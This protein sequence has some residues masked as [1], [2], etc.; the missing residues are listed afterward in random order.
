ME[1]G[2]GRD[3]GAARDVASLAWDH[4]AQGREEPPPTAPFDDAADLESFPVMARLGQVQRQ[5]IALSDRIEQL[6]DLLERVEQAIGGRA[7]SSVG[8]HV[9]DRPF[10]QGVTARANP[11]THPVTPPSTPRALDTGRDEALASVRALFTRRRPWWQ[12][13][14][15]LIKG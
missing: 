6:G 12:R 11:M 3:Q 7:L 14:P 2:S 13:L 4:A 5:I 10:P 9:D 15:D 1:R 8:W